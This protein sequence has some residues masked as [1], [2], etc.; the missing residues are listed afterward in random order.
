MALPTG[1]ISVL[2]FVL[3]VGWSVPVAIAAGLLHQH[4]VAP[5]GRIMRI[6]VLE[7][8]LLYLVGVGVVWAI[9]GNGVDPRLWEIPATLIASGIGALL[10]LTALP[11]G[12]GSWIVTK[13]QNVDSETALRFTTYGWPV[14]MVI[15]F[16]LFIAPGGLSRGHLF[17]LA[18]V[19]IC[20]AGFC[21]ISLTFAVALILE[22]IIAVLLPGLIGIVL[23]SRRQTRREPRREETF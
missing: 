4:G 10:L 9:A 21:G 18:G 15:V 20:V 6:V 22:A 16:G 11:L 17:E 1:L 19:Q 5:F 8:G 2:V 12:L 13:V 23:I 3:T 14:A 7:A